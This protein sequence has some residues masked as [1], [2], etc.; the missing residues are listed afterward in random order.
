MWTKAALG[1]GQAAGSLACSA[2]TCTLPQVRL[3]QQGLTGLQQ[4][5]LAGVAAPACADASAAGCRAAAV[6]SPARQTTHL[7]LQRAVQKVQQRGHRLVA[8]HDHF[9]QRKTQCQLAI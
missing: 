1:L 8:Q 6:P 5:R 2:R 7:L 4:L 9:L 3:P